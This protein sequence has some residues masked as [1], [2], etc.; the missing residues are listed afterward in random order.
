[1]EEDRTL[2][3]WLAGDH[4]RLDDLWARAQAVRLS[5][6]VEARRLYRDFAEGLRAH[7]TAEEEVVFAG[8]ERDPGFTGEALLEQLREEHREILAS[9]AELLAAVEQGGDPSAPAAR[10]RQLLWSHNAREET[11]LYPG[12]SEPWQGDSPLASGVRR[13]LVP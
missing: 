13:R 10:L 9:L 12:L 5:R 1:M 7:L 8:L 11:Q 2:G 3:E 4:R 6:P